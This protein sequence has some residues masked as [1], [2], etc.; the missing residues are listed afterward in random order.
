MRGIRKTIFTVFIIMTGVPLLWA[1]GGSLP[2][3][4]DFSGRQELMDLVADENVSMEIVLDMEW[5][6]RDPFDAA[7]VKRLLMPVPEPAVVPQAVPDGAFVLSGLFWNC[8]RPTVI[9]ND[10]MLGIGDKLQGLTVKEIMEG[11]VILTDGKRELSLS[12]Q[13]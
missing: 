12:P 4:E 13:K 1:S 10:V 3:P 2:D 7:A 8:P 6:E 9:I 11:F 5:G